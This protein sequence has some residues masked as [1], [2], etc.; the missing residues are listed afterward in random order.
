MMQAMQSQVPQ[1]LSALMALQEGMQ[2]GQVSPVT[3]EGTPTVAGQM[4]KAATQQ[5]MPPQMPPQMP[6]GMPGMA[7][8]AQQAGIAAQIQ[9]MQ[10]Q[11][12][13]EALMQQ[14]AQ[15]QQRPPMMAAGGVASLNPRIRDFAQGGIVGY[16]TAGMTVDPT[17]LEGYGVDETGA[18]ET[19]QL[20]YDPTQMEGYLIEE[21]TRAR[22]EAPELTM[23][24]AF[25]RG[26]SALERSKP[27]EVT[28]E[29]VLE[30]L[31]RND[32]AL[33]QYLESQGINVNFLKEEIER[34]AARGREQSEYYDRLAR[35]TTEQQKR[36]G[37]AT[38]LMGARG[39]R[40]GETLAAGAGAANRAED[41]AMAQ[42][43]RFIEAKFEIQN[44][45]AREKRLLEQARDQT[46]RGNFAG[47][48]RSL[49]K[50]EIERQ[51]R[52]QKQA[53]FYRAFGQTLGSGERAETRAEASR[54][55]ADVR[56]ETARYLADVRERLGLARA[57]SG[58]R[59]PIVRR[60]ETDPQGNKIAIMSDGS[61]RPLGFKSAD[62]EYRIGKM[63]QQLLK[64]GPPGY[65]RLPYEE[66]RQIATE[67]VV[68][69]SVAPAAGGEAPPPSAAPGATP[70]G[71]KVMTMDDVRAT[72]ARAGKTEQQVMEAAKAKGYTIQ[73]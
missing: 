26:I 18:G 65:R 19:R 45:V 25:A 47:T 10:Q 64:D 16:A 35:E 72:A 66:Q 11:K 37:L 58:G 24:E 6:Q 55:G 59:E 51:N 40:L 32:P 52:E 7:Q 28:P 21:P 61:P 4:A 31:N 9:A 43:R 8:M 70:T 41:L 62:F 38:Y 60:V 63:Q 12:M 71:G 33:N 29:Q 15:A 3:P 53:D 67:Y 23:Q 42:S 57:G 36:R 14:A 20:Q 46:A 1:E 56:A 54:Y 50:A 39:S 22:E 69:K 27:R 68:G 5:M 48:Q 49:E 34:V 17:Q 30:R 44:S 73:Q 2:T 13:Q